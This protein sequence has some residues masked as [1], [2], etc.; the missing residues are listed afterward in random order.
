MSLTSVKS[1]SKY[2][3][4][5]YIS[6]GLT[7]IS[8]IWLKQSALRKRVS[9][10]RDF[11]IYAAYSLIFAALLLNIYGLRHV[12]LTDMAV[13]LPA[14]FIVIPILSYFF[15]NERQSLRSWFGVGLICIGTAV[16]SL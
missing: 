4:I 14:I 7:A 10:I 12:P 13:I 11:R 8:Q 5:L 15:L 16:Y 2:H 9:P 3:L 1:V 6:V